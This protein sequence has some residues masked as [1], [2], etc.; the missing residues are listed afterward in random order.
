MN[1]HGFL[2]VGVFIDAANVYMN[3]GQK[4][5]YDVLRHYAQAYGMIQRLNAYMTFD[6]ERSQTDRDYRDR[7]V[8]WQDLVRSF[9]YHTTIQDVRWLIDPDSGRRYAKAN[10]DIQLVVDMIGQANNL[11]HLILVTGDGDFVR[12]IQYV[13]GLGCRVEVIGFDNVSQDL[14]KEADVY[15]S[16]YMI[17]E[18][19]PTNRRD[20]PWG[21]VGST[22]RGI[23]YY[24]K[25]DEDYGF[26]AFLE[27][28]SPLAWISD[29]RHP[30]SP[31]RAVFFH[32][33]TLPQGIYPRSLPNRW[34]IFEFEVGQNERGLFAEELRTVSGKREREPQEPR[35]QAPKETGYVPLW[36]RTNGLDE[37]RL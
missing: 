11:D 30:D 31:Y 34:T 13:R 37:T 9:G 29:P 28:I 8:G 12:P 26:L 4:M 21:S 14:R 32:D 16:G 3:G 10:A 18:L 5:R 24:H 1:N 33:S 15:T 17:P 25:A 27:K 22:V 20:T 23:C 19:L 36:E 2:K 6:E 35:E 7:A